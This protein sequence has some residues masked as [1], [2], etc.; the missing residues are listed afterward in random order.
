MNQD[1][2]SWDRFIPMATLAYNTKVNATTG[3]TPF[4]AWMGRAPRLPIDVIIPS[5]EKRYATEDQYIQDTMRRFEVMFSKMKENAETTFRRNARLYSGRVDEY[6]I[7]DLV[8]CFTKK[9]VKGKI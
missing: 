1:D 5:P 4:E 2:K 3:V 9:Q 6:A 7:G 8:W